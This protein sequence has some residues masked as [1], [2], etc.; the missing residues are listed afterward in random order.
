M[1]DAVF[2]D[3]ALQQAIQSA[4]QNVDKTDDLFKDI[5]AQL[6][7]STKN[8]I[9]EGVS[10]DGTPFAA[11]SQATLDAYAAKNVSAIGI[12]RKSGDMLGHTIF[13]SYDENQTEVGTSAL[14][15]AMM[16]FG[17][18][19]AQFPN[20]WGDIPERRFLGISDQD[21]VDLTDIIAE[22]LEGL[23]D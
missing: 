5:G 11:R 13:Y 8:R 21:E 20:L 4:I 14:Q 12:L 22:W 16:N 6:V 23:A 9:E 17:G 10:P 19:K 3:E 15:A 2:A 18:T 1:T 7:L